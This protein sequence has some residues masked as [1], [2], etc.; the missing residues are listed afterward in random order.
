[1]SNSRDEVK[2]IVAVTAA[3]GTVAAMQ[4][5]LPLILENAPP[6]NRY[7]TNRT[8]TVDILKSD[9]DCYNLLHMYVEPFQRLIFILKGTGR[10]H[11]TI[12]CTVQEQVA[13]FLHTISFNTRNRNLK[14]YFKRSGETI[15]RYFH[16]VLDA[17]IDMED[18]FIRRP[19]PET[20]LEICS[21]H[22]LG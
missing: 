20:P 8:F 19:S 17:I 4:G 13:I 15:S 6:R 11:D 2:R 12:H 14:F 1:M 10:V 16:T 7:F 21:R 3:L 9:E 22:R 18:I 5:M